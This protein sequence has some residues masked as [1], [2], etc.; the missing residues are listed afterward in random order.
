[1]SSPINTTP[2][3]GVER[4]LLHQFLDD[5]HPLVR[6]LRRRRRLV[7]VGLATLVGTQMGINIGMTVGLL[8]ITGMTLP[9]VSYG[10]SSLV[11]G[12]VMVG[13]VMN[14]AMRR[15]QYLWQ[16]SFEFDDEVGE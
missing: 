1:M 3:P 11:M 10:G 16:R 6:S 5:D 8:P 2:T 13:L 4:T 15:P 12:F 9:F 14:I 7:C